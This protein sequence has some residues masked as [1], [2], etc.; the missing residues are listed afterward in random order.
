MQVEKMGVAREKARGDGLAF[1]RIHRAPA[2]QEVA[3][4]RLGQIFVE[5][6]KQ[7]ARVVI[8]LPDKRGQQHQPLDLRGLAR[9]QALP[10]PVGRQAS[11]QRAAGLAVQVQPQLGALAAAGFENDLA[12]VLPRGPL[13][14]QIDDA[15][16]VGLPVEHRGGPLSTSTRSSA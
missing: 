2:Q 4:A 10:P 15:A 13:G 6:F 7:Q 12:C 8:G 3:V 9:L 1:H 11:A 5:G 14:H 16:G